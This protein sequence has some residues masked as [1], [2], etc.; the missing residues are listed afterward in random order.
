MDLIVIWRMDI[1]VPQAIKLIWL[2][3]QN[4]ILRIKIRVIK[5]REHFVILPEPKHGAIL[6]SQMINYAQHKME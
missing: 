6:I 1:F 3:L 2:M 5:I 4:V